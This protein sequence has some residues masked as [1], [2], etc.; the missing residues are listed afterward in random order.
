MKI[1]FEQAMQRLEEISKQLSESDATID[2]SLELYS[3]GVK[4]IAF[5]NDKLKFV[6]KKIEEIDNSVKED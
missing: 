1:T 6:S 3:E 2:K 5:C 4:L